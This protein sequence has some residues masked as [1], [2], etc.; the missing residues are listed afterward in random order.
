MFVN[1]FSEW[2]NWPYCWANGQFHHH[3][4]NCALCYHLLDQEAPEVS[5]SFPLSIPLLISSLGLT[6]E[7]RP[8]CEEGTILL[9][10]PVIV[11]ILWN[12][13]TIYKIQSSRKK[14]SSKCVN[15]NL[16]LYCISN[17][18]NIKLKFIVHFSLH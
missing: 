16:N 14:C 3:Y 6:Q 13:F 18:R 10:G 9:P 5:V 12:D 11:P 7:I 17:Y 8:A 2:Q 1:Y 4:I 15:R